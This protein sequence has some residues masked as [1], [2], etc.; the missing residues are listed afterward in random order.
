MRFTKLFLL[1]FLSILSVLALSACKTKPEAHTTHTWVEDPETP[2]TC[3]QDGRRMGR[4]CTGCDLVIE[5]EVI[6]ATQLHTYESNLCTQCGDIEHMT[7][8]LLFSLLA[9]G[10]A[11]EVT[12]IEDTS[13][14]EIYIGA[15]HEGLPITRIGS[16][17]FQGQ[18]S[19]E[20]VVMANGIEEIGEYAFQDCFSLEHVRFSQQLSTIEKYAF[21]QCT[22]L[23]SVVFPSSLKT[24]GSYA[25]GACYALESLCFAEGSLLE[26]IENNAFLVCI[27]LKDCNLSQ[28]TRLTFLGENA[29]HT[30]TDLTVVILPDSLTEC[31]DAAFYVCRELRKIR[32]PKAISKLPQFLLTNCGK[33][34]NVVYDGTVE[35]WL[36]LE[37]D[38]NWC[39]ASATCKITCTDGALNPDGSPFS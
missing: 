23:Q 9:G 12:G 11:Y 33:L 3:T 18:H 37:K 4:H 20:K 26:R 34:E 16:G 38:N 21:Y 2:P 6:P 10:T 31:G 35:E 24:I 14:S 8:G 13:R 17:A 25:F 27:R 39:D 36:A 29:F 28:N 32:L 5:G 22:D 19:L 30:C 1:I 15:T 7:E